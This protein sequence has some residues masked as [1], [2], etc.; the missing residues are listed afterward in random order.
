MVPL[1]HAAKL[2]VART[3]AYVADGADGIAI[4]NVTKPEAPA[5]YQM[6]NADGAITDA[7]DIVVAAT[8]ASLFGYVADGANGLKVLQLFSPETQPKFYGFSPQ[9]KPQLVATWPTPSPAT[10]L[11][12]GLERDR[13]VD[14]TGGQI[15]VLGRIGARPFTHPE[16]QNLYLDSEGKPWWVTDQ[17]DGP[18]GITRSRWIGSRI[19]R[20]RC[21][22]TEGQ[23]PETMISRATSPG[24]RAARLNLRNFRCANPPSPDVTNGRNRHDVCIVIA[25]GVPHV[26]IVSLVG[27]R[28]RRVTPA[29]CRQHR[30]AALGRI[31]DA[32]TRRW[33]PDRRPGGRRSARD[34]Q[35]CDRRLQ[36]RWSGRL[37]GLG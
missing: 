8:N 24:R 19:G 9:P 11:S 4:V 37:P 27:L 14:E 35:R 16:M 32:C 17:V 29:H 26:R 1:A 22:T 10:S 31:V 18:N 25:S 5:L 3:Y 7:R 15:A 13:A 34:Q 2:H 33:V 20:W 30:G 36:W 28:A 23:W 21:R 6:F 12:R